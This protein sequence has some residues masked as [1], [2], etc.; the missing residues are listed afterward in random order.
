M[1][2]VKINNMVIDIYIKDVYR[3]IIRPCIYI[4]TCSCHINI[5]I[6]LN[7]IR[8]EF[9]YILYR[10]NLFSSRFCSM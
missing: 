4:E 2:Y 8:L 9:I 1:Q 10:N 3:I 7:I 6:F 5:Y